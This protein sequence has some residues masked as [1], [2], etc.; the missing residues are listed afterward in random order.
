MHL[1]HVGLEMQKGVG[2]THETG[3][4]EI[5]GEVGLLGF[6]WKKV[7][8]RGS[9]GVLRMALNPVVLAR[10]GGLQR[11]SKQPFCSSR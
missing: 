2:T 8:I 7:D 11:G 4:N 9:C 10:V 3:F 1:F 6:R 5:T